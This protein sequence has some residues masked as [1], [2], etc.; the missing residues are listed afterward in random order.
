M[1][2]GF[3]YNSSKSCPQK[4]TYS[5]V[6]LHLFLFAGAF[7]V[8]GPFCADA[9][10]PLPL[11]PDAFLALEFPVPFNSNCTCMAT[12]TKRSGINH[13]SLC[14]DKPPKF[15]SINMLI[16]PYSPGLPFEFK[17]WSSDCSFSPVVVPSVA[18][19]HKIMYKNQLIKGNL[20]LYSCPWP[21]SNEG[22]Q[23][24]WI[25]CK[26][27]KC[28]YNFTCLLCVRGVLF[29]TFVQGITITLFHSFISWF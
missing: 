24:P 1:K 25:Y 11:P 7:A 12:F 13:T 26:E 21:E 2:V 22:S 3:I 9:E 20:V 19:F 29:F 15:Q 10:A 4:K 28:R 18:S 5:L 17:L 16:E 27:K 6:F 14:K 8:W 23:L